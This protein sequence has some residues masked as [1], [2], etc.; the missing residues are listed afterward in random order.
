MLMVCHL[1]IALAIALAVDSHSHYV[2]AAKRQQQQT[3]SQ[4]QNTTQ[5]Q[6]GNEQSPLVVQPLPTKKTAEEAARETR[7]TKEK[8]VS[9]WW[10]WFLGVLTICALFGQ[11]AVF[12]AQAYFLRGTLLATEA[13]ANAAKQAADFIPNVERGHIVG[14]GPWPLGNGLACVAIANRGKTAAILTKVE[15]GFCAE[16]QFPVDAPVSELLKNGRLKVDECCITE[17]VLEPTSPPMALH[18]LKFPLSK[19]VGK[20][21]YGKFTYSILFDSEEHFSTFKL[22]VPQ[23]WPNAPSMGLPGSYLDWK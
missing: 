11:L 15:W 7:E 9:D 1:V 8:T 2:S 17:D 6:R 14:G 20:I 21:F 12:I 4:Q 18:D 16:E 10:T 5:D 22:K 19:V 13:A 3:Q 23:I